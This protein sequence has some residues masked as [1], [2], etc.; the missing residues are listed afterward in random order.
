MAD[1]FKKSNKDGQLKTCKFC[2]QPV[3]WHSIL[4]RWY[5][6]G[7]ESLHINNCER[8]KKHHHNESMNAAESRRQQH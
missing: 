6:V 1:V 5:D 4:G 3:W 8:R 7:G 2:R